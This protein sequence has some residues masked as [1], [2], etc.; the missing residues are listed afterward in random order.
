[1]GNDCFLKSPVEDGSESEDCSESV[2]WSEICETSPFPCGA[3][4][5]N[6][7]KEASSQCS[8]SSSLFVGWFIQDDFCTDKG[9]TSVFLLVKHE[10]KVV[11]G[12]LEFIE[13][14]SEIPSHIIAIFLCPF[15]CFAFK[16]SLNPK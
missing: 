1:M 6:S 16:E 4:L 12:G 10:F 5:S 7:V 2:D 11:D 8:V 13:S 14:L 15:G 9:E 3:S